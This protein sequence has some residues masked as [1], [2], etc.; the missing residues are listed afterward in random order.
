MVSVLRDE[1]TVEIPYTEL[2]IGD[3]LLITEN[4]RLPADVR[5]MKIHSEDL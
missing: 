3:L 4:L 1:N 2:V 5:L